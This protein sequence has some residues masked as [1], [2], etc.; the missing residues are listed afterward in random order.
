ML[1]LTDVTNTQGLFH[2]DFTNQLQQLEDGTCSTRLPRKL[3]HAP[4]PSNKELTIGRLR[5]TTRKLEKIQRLEEYH[6]VMEQQLEQG[7]L[8]IEPEIST[9]EVIHCI[10]HQP[11][12]RDRAESTKMRIVYGCSAK[13]ASQ[14]PSLYDCL[15]VGPPLQPMTFD[16]LIRNRLKL[17][18]I[19]GD[20]QKAFLQ[21]RVDPRDKDALCLLWYGNLD[22]RTVVQ[23]GFTRVIFGSGPSPYILG[24]ILKKHVRQYADKY[25]S[26]T[27]ELLK[28]TYV[29][30]VQSGGDHKEELFKFKEEATKIMEDGGFHLHNVP[31]LEE[32]QTIEDDVVPSQASLTYPVLEGETGPQETKILGV[33]WNKTKDKLSIG[34]IKPLGSVGHGPLTKR[35]MLSA[36][37]CLSLAGNCC[38]SH[39]HQKDPLW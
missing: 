37:R 39:Y 21:I 25:P 23:C 5:S 29:D 20:I 10:P 33:P 36:V 9:G 26:T 28:N 13:A 34:L 19:T 3:D 8:E 27:D 7:V 4:L 32:P 30:D 6:R 31:E 16:I 18:C 22:L 35:K 2:E 1:G 15:E 38:T 14:E 11:V 24:V 17:L 12:M